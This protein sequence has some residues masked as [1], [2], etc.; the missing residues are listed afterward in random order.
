MQ[1]AEFALLK[2]E[3]DV[4]PGT[5]RTGNDGVVG[6]PPVDLQRHAVHF[7]IVLNHLQVNLVSQCFVETALVKLLGAVLHG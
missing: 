3:V 7:E 6:C 5:G 4:A 2:F 1:V